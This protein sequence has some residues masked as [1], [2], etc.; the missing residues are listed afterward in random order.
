MR[1]LEIRIENLKDSLD[2]FKE[3]FNRLQSGEK[4]EKEEYIAVSSIEELNKLLSPKKIQILNFLKENKVSS[5]NE[6][7]RKLG[8][9]YKN[10]YTDLKLFEKLGIIRFEKENGKL[11]PKVLYD[12]IEVKV[13]L[14]S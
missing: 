8:R 14:H 11:I 2:K 3:V 10:V 7:A 6:L 5:I 1:T 12:E 4:V 9:D 13:P